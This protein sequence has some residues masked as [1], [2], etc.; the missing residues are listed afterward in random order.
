[1]EPSWANKCPLTPRDRP[2][3]GPG[4]GVGGRG[5]PLPKGE[6][7]G[8]KRKLPRP[9]TPRG[10]VGFFKSLGKINDLG[11]F[12]PSWRTSWGRVGVSWTVLGHPG[13]FLG[14]PGS[15]LEPSW[16]VLVVA[17]ADLRPSWTVLGGLGGH[18]GS[19]RGHLG[20]SWSHLEQEKPLE[21]PLEQPFGWPAGRAEAPGGVLWEKNQNQN[22]KD[23]ARQ[24]PL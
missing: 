15:I 3:P 17:S 12:G 1:L 5:K 19:L 7:G 23:L 16:A 18:L 10:L 6:E 14:G 4:E 11:F 21:P 2:R 9:P 20:R 13:G 24:A 8:W 22:R